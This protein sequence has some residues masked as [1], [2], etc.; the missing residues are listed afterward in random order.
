MLRLLSL[1]LAGFAL[2]AIGLLSAQAQ[3]SKKA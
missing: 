3:E 2:G 1:L